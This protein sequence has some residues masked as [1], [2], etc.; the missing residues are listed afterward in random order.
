MQ[1]N[2]E[3][4][5][6]IMM[7]TD[8]DT[9]FYQLKDERYQHILAK[10][11]NIE[12]NKDEELEFDLELPEGMEKYYDDD[13]FTTLIQ[14][15]VFDSVATS[16][17]AYWTEAEKEVLKTLE[18]RLT[19]MFSKYDIELNGKTYLD[20]LAEKGYIVVEDTD[21]DLRL[22]AVKMPEEKK[23]Y[24]DDQDDFA[25]IKKELSGSALIY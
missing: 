18:E 19:E 6:K 11:G 24:F 12:Y 25:F 3:H 14:N 9:I 2:K 22:M 21:N 8:K 4:F 17:K 10:V 15:A 20:A 16:V 13:T 23:Y 5:Y 7:N 1:Q